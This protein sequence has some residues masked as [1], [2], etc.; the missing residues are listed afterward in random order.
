MIDDK[1]IYI[2]TINSE[3]TLILDQVPESWGIPFRLCESG[4]D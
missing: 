2:V 3:L 1:I 4:V